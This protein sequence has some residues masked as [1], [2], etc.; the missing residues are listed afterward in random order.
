MS[1]NIYIFSDLFTLN[2]G[3][4]EPINRN[5]TEIQNFFRTRV[6]EGDT[7][8]SG[9]DRGVDRIIAEMQ[10]F[11][12]NFVRE[13]SQINVPLFCFFPISESLASSR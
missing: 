5:R 8:P 13:L 7:S 12:E 6:C 4:V 9:V 1:N 2:S 10:P 11:L 3:N